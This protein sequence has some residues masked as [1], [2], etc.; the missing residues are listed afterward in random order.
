MSRY[1]TEPDVMAYFR[2]DRCYLERMARC[3]I[4]NGKAEAAWDLYLENESAL[5]STSLL[6]VIAN[7]CY[8]TGAFL[9]SARA[10]D[11]LCRVDSNPDH[12]VGK[13]G[14]IV[15]T[16]RALVTQ[17]APNELIDELLQLARYE[18]HHIDE[19]DQVIGSALWN[20]ASTL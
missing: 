5:H 8:I 14:A 6:H 4:A 11:A 17:Q 12:T 7:D 18:G 19:L 20:W 16:F 15:G 9:I 3:Y 13:R 10:F 1:S 2:T